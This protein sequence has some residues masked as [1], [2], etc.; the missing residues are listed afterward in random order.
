MKPLFRIHRMGRISRSLFFQTDR[1]IPAHV[2]NTRERRSQREIRPVHPH[3]CGEHQNRF[4]LILRFLGS[5][6]RMWGTP[7]NQPRLGK[8][9]RFIPTH[10]G[11]TPQTTPLTSPQTVHPHACG[12]HRPS[13]HPPNDPDGSS[14]RMW[15]T[16][17]PQLSGPLGTRFIPT[18]V[19]NTIAG[20]GVLPLQT[21]HPHACGEHLR[22]SIFSMIAPGSSPRMWGTQWQNQKVRY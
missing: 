1:F 13:V 16:Q 22:T 15:G 4:G 3:A 8:Y 9:I 2:G 7:A 20:I 18:H 10:V 12:E 19:G 17:V 21:V 5:S 14:P 11:N 6:P